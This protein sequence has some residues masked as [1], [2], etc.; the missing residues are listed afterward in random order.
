MPCAYTDLIIHKA[1]AWKMIKLEN[2]SLT[3]DNKRYLYLLSLG[4]SQQEALL[5]FC[6][7]ALLTLSI[8]FTSR[9]AF[10]E[11]GILKANLFRK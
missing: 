8:Y 9:R 5:P 11:Y 6:R 10:D 1:D 4:A 7:E 3:F 2:V